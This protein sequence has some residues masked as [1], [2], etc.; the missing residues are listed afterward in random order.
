MFGS[1]LV[2]RN[3]RYRL[4]FTAADTKN[5]RP[6]EC[7]WPAHLNAPLERYLVVHREVLLAQSGGGAGIRGLWITQSGLSMKTDSVAQMMGIRTK[8]AFGVALYPHL[9]RYTAATLI[10]ENDPARIADAVTILGHTSLETTERHY[11]MA[12]AGVAATRYDELISSRMRK[13]R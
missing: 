13:R 8:A 5:K 3:G 9:T 2:R 1:S 11:N 6:F 7:D 4:Q 12:E 10:A